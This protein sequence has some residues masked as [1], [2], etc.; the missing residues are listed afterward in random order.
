MLVV[1]GMVNTP[2][3]KQ[4]VLLIESDNL[5]ARVRM[6]IGATSEGADEEKTLGRIPRERYGMFIASG[7]CV[8]R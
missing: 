8:S 4:P 1:P 3:G 5:A 7:L 2:P 6:A